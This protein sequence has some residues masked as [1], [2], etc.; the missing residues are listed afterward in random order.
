MNLKK[1]SLV[2]ILISSAAMLGMPAISQLSNPALSVRIELE[3]Q[4]NP[5]SYCGNGIVWLYRQLKQTNSAELKQLVPLVTLCYVD[6]SFG[7]RAGSSPHF[8]QYIAD[9]ENQY[10][11]VAGADA[12]KFSIEILHPMITT[13]TDHKIGG[14][15]NFAKGAVVIE[16]AIIYAQSKPYGQFYIPSLQKMHRHYT[17]KAGLAR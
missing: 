12:V 8:G 1:R 10:G 16:N 4:E 2:N 13:I 17:W 9:I 14:D 6:P 7:G 15:I 11:E 5:A 3:I